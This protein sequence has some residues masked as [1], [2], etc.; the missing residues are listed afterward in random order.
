MRLNVMVGF[1]SISYK[2]QTKLKKAAAW[3]VERILSSLTFF[4]ELLTFQSLCNT[5][6]SCWCMS[7]KWLFKCNGQGSFVF[8]SFPCCF[9][10][11]FV[12]SPCSQWSNLPHQSQTIM[13]FIFALSFTGVA[14][15]IY[16]KLPS[17]LTLL[18]TRYISDSCC[19]SVVVEQTVG[20]PLLVGCALSSATCSWSILL[21]IGSKQVKKCQVF[22]SCRWMPL[23]F[24]PPYPAS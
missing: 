7:T 11:C 19:T 6:V 2:S 14:S 3:W 1:I 12:S 20:T 13:A 16:K 10:L 24:D 23:A 8:F 9:P 4:L 22:W 15:A 21:I 5:S 17:V 18:L